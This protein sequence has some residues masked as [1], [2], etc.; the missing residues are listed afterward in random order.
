M[1]WFWVLI[2]P[3]SCNICVYFHCPIV[4]VYAY[5]TLFNICTVYTT[6]TAKAY[7]LLEVCLMGQ[8]IIIF[9]LPYRVHFSMVQPTHYWTDALSSKSLD[10]IF[11]V[12]MLSKKCNTSVKQNKLITLMRL[13]NDSNAVKLY[14]KTN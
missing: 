5:V 3:F 12:S 14:W 9:D 2:I 10:M 13:R 7:N 1:R 8:L 6:I 11:F 4:I